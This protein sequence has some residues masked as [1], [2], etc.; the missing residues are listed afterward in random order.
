MDKVD[1]LKV[2][3]G[4]LDKIGVKVELVGNYPWVYINKING[5]LVTEIFQGN[6]GFTVAFLPIRKDQ[7][8]KFTDITEIF[9]LL[10]KYCKTKEDEKEK[11]KTS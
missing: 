9:K 4:R 3:Q 2:F 6:H 11:G 10:R 7:E 8:L 1:K 5:Q